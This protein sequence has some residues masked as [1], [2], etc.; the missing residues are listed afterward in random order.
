M[1]WNILAA[2]L[3]VLSIAALFGFVIWRK[4]YRRAV[5]KA[6]YEDFDLNDQE[7]EAPNE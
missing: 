5:Y 1:I 7:E 2:V 4:H 6:L 3:I